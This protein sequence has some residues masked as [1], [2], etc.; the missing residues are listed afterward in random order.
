MSDFHSN[1]ILPIVRSFQLRIYENRFSSRLFSIFAFIK[2][3]ND[4]ALRSQQVY[5]LVY[6]FIKFIFIFIHQV[7]SLLGPKNIDPWLRYNLYTLLMKESQII[8]TWYKLCWYIFMIITSNRYDLKKLYWKC[9]Q[10][11][12]DVRF[13]NLPKWA[14]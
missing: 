4:S 7:Y 2:F 5:S 8:L 9:S 12:L 10:L 13:L 1:V 3:I 6:I 14:P 11:T